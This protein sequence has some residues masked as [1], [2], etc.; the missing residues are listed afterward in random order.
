M[1]NLY[2]PH[3]LEHIRTEVKAPWMLEAPE[4]CPF[5]D[6]QTQSAKYIDNAWLIEDVVPTVVVPEN[7][8]LAQGHYIL[9]VKN[10]YQ[11][12]VDYITSITDPTQKLIAEIA[13][14]RT[15]PWSRSSPFLNTVATDLGFSDKLDAWFIE[16]SKIIL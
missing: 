4:E 6:I 3:T 11:N 8:S 2:S 12:V 13:F 1:R 10:E 5:Y 16:G 9:A 15:N 7:I 14:Y